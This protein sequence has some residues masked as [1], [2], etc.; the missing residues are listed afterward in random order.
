MM[1]YK[2]QKF[3][4]LT[5]VAALRFVKWLMHWGCP[6]YLIISL[7]NDGSIVYFVVNQYRDINI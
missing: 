3:G 5:D 1:E 7:I 6:K 4:S 2:R